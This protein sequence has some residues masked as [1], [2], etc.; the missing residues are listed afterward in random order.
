MGSIYS[1]YEFP[2]QI[3]KDKRQEE[4]RKPQSIFKVV[5]F[6]I[7][8]L[9]KAFT[10]SLVTY[11][12]CRPFFDWM[13]HMIVNLELAVPASETFLLLAAWLQLETHA[14]RKT[15]KP[16]ALDH[17]RHTTII[18]N[19]S[20]ADDTDLENAIEKHQVPQL[21]VLPAAHSEEF[22]EHISG[23]YRE[24]AP[25]KICMRMLEHNAAGFKATKI[26]NFQRRCE[27]SV[28]REVSLKEL[29][30]SQKVLLDRPDEFEILEL[31]YD[32]RKPKPT[33]QVDV[34]P[35]SVEQT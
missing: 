20:F 33:D 14:W 4:K 5:I 24:A 8:L 10:K 11:V 19:F 26:D 22:I 32:I 21:F 28:V 27:D 31:D 3:A 9:I 29:L 6:F 30:C 12:L 25:Y 2:S 34:D 15:K 7:W 1:C 13:Q 18:H 16:P 35:S 23:L 17:S